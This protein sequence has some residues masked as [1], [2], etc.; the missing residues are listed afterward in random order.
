MNSW[1]NQEATGLVA[2]EFLEWLEATGRKICVA[3]PHDG[4]QPILT[5]VGE[6]VSEFLGV[7]HAELQRERT[8]LLKET[9]ER[10]AVSRLA[11]GELK[12][13]QQAPG[14]CRTGRCPPRRT[15]GTLGAILVSP[16][17]LKDLEAFNDRDPSNPTDGSS[18][19]QEAIQE[20]DHPPGATQGEA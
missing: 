14:G 15:L 12:G 10:L 8:Q 20:T 11:A 2:T 13:L 16:Q 17:T 18:S 7:D 6:F 5:P 9:R 4:Y 3:T 1:A 19:Q